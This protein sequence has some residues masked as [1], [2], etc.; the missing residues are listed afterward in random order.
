MGTAG[1]TTAP[2]SAN[3][4]RAEA[5]IAAATWSRASEGGTR[6]GGGRGGSRTATAA[7]RCAAEG[8]EG[9]TV[10]DGCE[11]PSKA[12]RAAATACMATEWNGATGGG[13]EGIG[14]M[15]VEGKGADGRPAAL[16]ITGW[17]VLLVLCCN[18][19]LMDGRT[20]R[21]RPCD[22]GGGGLDGASTGGRRARAE[23]GLRPSDG[24][25]L[26]C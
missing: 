19:L 20:E 8:C 6:E 21:R 25:A 13:G 26:C 18:G 11:A 22:G 24:A 2:A 1:T 10:E 15:A 12:R 3:D 5:T 7:L 9:C 23:D 4:R 14:I 17:L 16:L